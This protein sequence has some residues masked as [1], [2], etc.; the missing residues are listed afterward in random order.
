MHFLKRFSE[1][2]NPPKKHW[3]T[4]RFARPLFFGFIY[5]LCVKAFLFIGFFA[6]K[7]SGSGALQLGTNS[8]EILET[9]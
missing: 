1:F 6:V 8:G 3:L 4:R 7:I 9:Y 2:V 5:I